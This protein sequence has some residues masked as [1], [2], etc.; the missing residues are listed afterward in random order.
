MG[1]HDNFA[2]FMKSE[3]YLF[4][5]YF[6]IFI[7]VINRFH[8][9]LYK[10]YIPWHP[11]WLF[12][13]GGGGGRMGVGLVTIAACVCGHCLSDLNQATPS[14]QFIMILGFLSKKKF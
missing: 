4:Y 3:K 14:E 2:E 13:L 9:P 8:G 7:I 1:L 5:T 10:C 12:S 11:R 6:V